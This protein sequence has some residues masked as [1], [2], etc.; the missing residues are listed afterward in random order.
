VCI[1]L[2]LLLLLLLRMCG[3][4]H[5]FACCG[6]AAATATG[7]LWFQGSGFQRGRRAIQTLGEFIISGRNFCEVE[8]CAQGVTGGCMFKVVHLRRACTV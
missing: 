3:G 2:L 1:V 4:V 7:C 8:T 6:A 5:A